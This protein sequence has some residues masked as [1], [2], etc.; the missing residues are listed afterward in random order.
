MK[1]ILNYLTFAAI[2]IVCCGAGYGVYRKSLAISEQTPSKPTPPPMVVEVTALRQKPIVDR[3]ELVGSLEAVTQGRV[4]TRTAG[5]IKTLPF[6]IG[7]YVRKGE[8]VVELD[9]S[10]A[11]EALKEAEAA[12]DVAKAQQE[13]SVARKE[14]LETRLNNYKAL[15]EK[16]VLTDQ[17]FKDL[18]S[19][20][21]VTQ[22]EVTVSDSLVNQ[23]KSALETSRLNLAETKIK[24]ALSGYVSERFAEEGDLADP[25]T[26]ILNIVDLERIHTLVHVVEKDYD[27]IKLGQSSV[28]RVDAYP[29]KEFSGKVIR[30][31]PR[32]DV[33]TRTAAVQIE[34]ENSENYLKPGMFARVSL[35]FGKKEQAGVVPMATVQHDGEERFVYLVRPKVN[36]IER[37][38]V[39]IGIE[40]GRYAEILQGLTPEDRIVALGSRLIRE[41]DQVDPVAAPA[42]VDESA[43]DTDP[44]LIE[45]P[46][47]TSE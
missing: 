34:I 11:Q 18:Q 44:L 20:F 4:Q 14:K 12:L 28:V 25:N 23:A 43:S 2:V 17:Q 41:G 39:T 6:D 35:Q 33:A 45:Y 24:S 30:I 3:V 29:S 32:I 8:L 22:A 9:D 37:R 26:P 7:D 15:L 46:V 27:K 21:K 16:N 1:S 38:N 10:Q 5:Y 31:A 40:D 36:I 42:E 47:I 19:D 13:A